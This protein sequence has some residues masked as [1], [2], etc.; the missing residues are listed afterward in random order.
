MLKKKTRKTTKPYYRRF[1]LFKAPNDKRLTKTISYEVSA[2]VETGSINPK[3]QDPAGVLKYMSFA[4]MLT[5]SQ[6]WAQMTGTNATSAI[7]KKF[8]PYG[9]RV[10]YIGEMN[11]LDSAGTAFNFNFILN[12]L[13]NNLNVSEQYSGFIHDQKMICFP[14]AGSVGKLTKYYKVP[15]S[16]AG[17]QGYP[18]Y[19]NQWFDVS[20]IYNAAASTDGILVMSSLYPPNNSGTPASPLRLGTIIVDLLIE[21]QDFY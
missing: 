12:P 16:S 9:I 3:F 15:P 13:W 5:R 6:A 10:T 8:R 7:F 4:Y 14:S 21:L 18:S 17:T 19:S 2:I 11:V 20:T 1:R